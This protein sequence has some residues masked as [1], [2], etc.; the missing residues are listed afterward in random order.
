MRQLYSQNGKGIKFEKL[1]EG[2]M[3]SK[4]LCK[5]GKENNVE[6][7]IVESV[8]SVLF[9]NVDPKDALGKLFMRSVKKEF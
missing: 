7:P 1:A 3:T 4:A 8:Y 9:D 2:V 5:L 6:L